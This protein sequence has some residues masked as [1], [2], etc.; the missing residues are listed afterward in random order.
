MSTGSESGTEFTER[1]GHCARCETE[2]VVDSRR[3]G[4]RAGRLLCEDCANASV[5]YIAECLDCG[6]T[7]S[8][9]GK[10]Y[11][12]YDCQMRVQQ[13]GN[14]HEDEKRVLG[15]ESHETVWRRVETDD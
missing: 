2:I 11:E 1:T 13:E 8:V 12:W 9:D 15:G 5:T 3:N 6:W 10:E 7:Y 4:A 14:S